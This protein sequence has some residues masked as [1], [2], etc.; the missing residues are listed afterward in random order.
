M[1]AWGN[2]KR[3][4]KELIRAIT[5]LFGFALRTNAAVS[6]WSY[7]FIFMSRRPGYCLMH[8]SSHCTFYISTCIWHSVI[9]GNINDKLHIFYA[10]KPVCAL[11]Y[12]SIKGKDQ[13][14]FLIANNKNS[15]LVK[16]VNLWVTP[17]VWDE[18]RLYWIINGIVLPDKMFLAELHNFC[19]FNVLFWKLRVAWC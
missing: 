16:G 3:L 13:F 18:W 19:L 2:A 12:E 14:H 5:V 15:S 6:F 8:R 10:N 4:F 7:S 9:L 1:I 11:K 17:Y